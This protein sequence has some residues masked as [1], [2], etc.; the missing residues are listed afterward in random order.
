MTMQKRR[1]NQKGMS[2]QKQMSRRDDCNEW[3]ETQRSRQVR[4]GV[5]LDRASRCRLPSIVRFEPKAA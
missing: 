2:V 5:I 3:T 4:F 1:L